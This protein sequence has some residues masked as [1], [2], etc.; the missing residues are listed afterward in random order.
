MSE[1]PQVISPEDQAQIEQQFAQQLGKTIIAYS[2]VETFLCTWFERITKMPHPMA[3]R[4]FYSQGGTYATLQLFRAVLDSAPPLLRDVQPLLVAAFNKLQKYSE[5]RNLMAH[6]DAL[7]VMIEESKYNG[8][9][10]IIRGREPWTMDPPG[11]EILTFQNLENAADNFGKLSAC[12]LVP[13]S[14]DGKD[15]EKSPGK[16]LPLVRLLPNLAHSKRLDPTTSKR[17]DIGELELPHWR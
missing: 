9:M 2:R 7:F 5:T 17:F 13:L 12:L 1:P 14:W 3:R 15:S 11:E 4:A 10:I 6:G 16:F 8:Q